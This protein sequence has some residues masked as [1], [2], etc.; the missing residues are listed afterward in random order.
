[1]RYTGLDTAVG[2]VRPDSSSAF[3][4]HRAAHI[5]AGASEA[6]KS[7]RATSDAPCCPRAAYLH[8]FTFR[9]ELRNRALLVVQAAM[10]PRR[11]AAASRE[12]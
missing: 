3:R 12:A 7:S 11:R 8:G 5:S 10:R 2:A 1:M 4:H 9:E 6:T